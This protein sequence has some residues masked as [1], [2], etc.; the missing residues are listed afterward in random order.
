VIE[1]SLGDEV[2][3]TVIA[4]GFDAA[5]PARNRSSG[6]APRL[7]ARSRIESARAG[8]LTSTLFEPVDAPQR[9]GAHEWLEAAEHWRR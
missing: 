9:A 4:A 1:D 2:R 8:K 6:S 3:V 5:G 7:A